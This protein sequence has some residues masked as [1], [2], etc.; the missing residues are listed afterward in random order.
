MNEFSKETRVVTLNRQ[1][2]LKRDY[3]YLPVQAGICIYHISVIGGKLRLNHESYNQDGAVW[4]LPPQDEQIDHYDLKAGDEVTLTIEINTHLGHLD[5][6]RVV[7][8][9]MNKELKFTY[10]V[11][12]R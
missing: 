10:R 3:C 5:Q 12:N 1:L 6:L 2:S 8:P 9:S 11:E 7:N 4:D